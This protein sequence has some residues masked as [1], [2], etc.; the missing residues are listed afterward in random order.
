MLPDPLFS[1][2]KWMG[3]RMHLPG[4]SNHSDLTDAGYLLWTGKVNLIRLESLWHKP[5]CLQ[6][7]GKL[8]TY[9]LWQVDPVM[10]VPALDQVYAPLLFHRLYGRLDD[11]I[12]GFPK[13]WRGESCP[14]RLANL[15][16][17]C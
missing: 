5:T 14:R 3:R 11:M 4:M 8:G 16:Q 17:R 15:Q 12:R 13:Q 2:K 1:A 6:N 7:G 10:L 9:A